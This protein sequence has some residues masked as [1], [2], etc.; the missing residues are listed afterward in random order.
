MY[1]PIRDLI[2]VKKQ[3]EAINKN[4]LKEVFPLLNKEKIDECK[5][6]KKRE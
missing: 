5:W 2:E 1:N 3:L 4:I 6:I